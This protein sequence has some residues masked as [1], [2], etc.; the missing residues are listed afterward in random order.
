MGLAAW[1]H[2][3]PWMRKEEEHV[4]A[5]ESDSRFKVVKDCVSFQALPLRLGVQYRLSL[6]QPPLGQCSLAGI[7]R[8]TSFRK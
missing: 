5:R 6:I 4:R 2:K 1:G 3:R 7:A 8:W